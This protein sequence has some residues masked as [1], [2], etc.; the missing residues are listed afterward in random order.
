LNV[1]ADVIFY[2]SNNTT[3]FNI[4]GR[5]TYGMVWMGHADVTDIVLEFSEKGEKVF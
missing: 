5:Y 4:I 3:T 2:I 1:H